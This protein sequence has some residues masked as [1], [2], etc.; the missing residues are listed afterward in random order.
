MFI[1][2]QMRQQLNI[3]VQLPHKTIYSTNGDPLAYTTHIH[4]QWLLSLARASNIVKQA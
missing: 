1:L 3:A 2:A 4:V